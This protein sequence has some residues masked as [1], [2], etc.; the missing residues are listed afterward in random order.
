MS[1]IQRHKVLR[2]L[3]G[4]TMVLGLS[5]CP[6]GDGDDDDGGGIGNMGGEREDDD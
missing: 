2:L 3:L 4:L 5:A 6:V 1:K